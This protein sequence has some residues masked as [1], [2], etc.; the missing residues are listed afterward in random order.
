MPIPCII[1]ESPLLMGDYTEYVCHFCKKKEV[2]IFVCP[3]G[4]YVCGSCHIDKRPKGF[5]GITWGSD[6]D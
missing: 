2:N 6:L 5:L 1:C 4:H 3:K